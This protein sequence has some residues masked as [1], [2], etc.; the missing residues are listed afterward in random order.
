LEVPG[1][2]SKDSGCCIERTLD[3]SIS[4]GFI[5][6]VVVSIAGSVMRL[7]EDWTIMQGQ[8]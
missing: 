3:S 7:L 1:S 6:G 8:P 4:S 5:L 2:G